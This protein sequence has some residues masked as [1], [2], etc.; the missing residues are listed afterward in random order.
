MIL[1]I[2]RTR[3]LVKE[4]LMGEDGNRISSMILSSLLEALKS[5]FLTQ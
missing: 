4:A 2:L 3:V 1:H 5:T